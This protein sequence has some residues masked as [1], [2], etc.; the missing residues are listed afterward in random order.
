MS[1]IGTTRIIRPHPPLSAIGITADKAHALIPFSMLSV[2]GRLGRIQS[3][4]RVHVAKAAI[5]RQ[6]VRN[7]LLNRV[8][9]AVPYHVASPDVHHCAPWAVLKGQAH[10]NVEAQGR[11]RNG[12]RKHQS[13]DGFHPGHQIVPKFIFARLIGALIPINAVIVQKRNQ[14]P[15]RIS[16]AMSASGAKRTITRVCPLAARSVQRR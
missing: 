12:D 1:A 6:H 10:R 13:H 11:R 9:L 16:V 15:M 4:G 14:R 8:V 7:A 2:F 5:A 3:E